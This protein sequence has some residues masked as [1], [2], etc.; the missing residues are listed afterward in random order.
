MIINTT[1]TPLSN[2]AAASHEGGTAKSSNA[3]AQ[4][5]G[6]TFTSDRVTL[7]EAAGLLVDSGKSSTYPE[8]DQVRITELKQQINAGTYTT[9]AARIAARFHQFTLN[10]Q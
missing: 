4:T 10:L 3:A 7:S 2:N 9:D 1:V 8:S 6:D 5:F